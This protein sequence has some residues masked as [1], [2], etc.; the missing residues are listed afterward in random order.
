MWTLHWNARNK[1]EKKKNSD[2]TNW[3]K[4]ENV[5]TIIL[6]IL[7]DK[8]KHTYC[9]Y[10]TTPSHS[11]WADVTKLCCGYQLYQTSACLYLFASLQYASPRLHRTHSSHPVICQN[12]YKTA[13]WDEHSGSCNH[14]QTMIIID[15]WTVPQSVNSPRCFMRRTVRPRPHSASWELPV[16]TDM[17]WDSRDTRSSSHPSMDQ[18]RRAFPSFATTVF[19][20]NCLL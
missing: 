9:T 13:I 18:A 12:W 5:T 16:R 11:L 10:K 7:L 2:K 15:F 6:L 1:G 14:R 3:T 17:T 20:E 4:Y 19:V 8:I